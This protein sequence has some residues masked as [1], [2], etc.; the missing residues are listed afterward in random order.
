MIQPINRTTYVPHIDGLR[1]AAVL[2]V[3]AYHLDSAWLPAGLGGVDIFFV[4]SGFVVSASLAEFRKSTPQAFFAYFYARRMLRILPALVVCLLVTNVA[5]MLFVP[6]AWLSDANQQTG[7]YAFFGLS[8][9]ILAETGNGY[10]APRA[11]FNPY[12]HTWSLGVEE[13]FYL[14][15]PP[16]F[17][18]WIAGGRSR[19]VSA[20]LFAMGLVASLVCAAWL[21]KDHG[22]LA[23]YMIYARFW[24]L[25]AGV[26]LYQTLVFT[27]HAFSEMHRPSTAPARYGAIA[28]ALLVAAGLVFARPRQFPFPGALL[29]VAGTL[30]LLGFLH[31]RE[32]RG[33]VM[34]ALQLPAVVFVGQISYSLYLWHWPVFVLLRWTTGLET[35]AERSSAV[36]LTFALAIASY[37]VI[38]RPPR[39]LGKLRA[40]PR[41]A[42]I[43]AGAFLV[44][45][46]WQ[47]AQFVTAKAPE[48][49]LTQVARNMPDWYAGRIDS[50]G[51]RNCQLRAKAENLGVV[52]VAIWSGV[53]CS[54]A[55]PSMPRLFVIGDSHAQA[56][57]T[58]MPVVAMDTGAEVYFYSN[59]GCPFLSLQLRREGVCVQQTATSTADMLA[60]MH[61][62]DILFMP[63]LRLDRLTDQ[64]EHRAEMAKWDT[65]LLA[66]DTDPSRKRAVDEA[67]AALKPFAERGVR[68]VFE[69]PKPLFRAPAFRCVDW[70]NAGNPICAP[71]LTMDR[72]ELVRYRAPVMQSFSE[73][74]RRVPGVT[75]WDPLPLL[76]PDS[77]CHATR[78]GH[79]LYYDGDH[80]SGYANRLLAPA[81]ERSM[82]RLAEKTPAAD[83]SS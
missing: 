57:A 5:E 78:D 50:V 73:I 33:I 56:Y 41:W 72:G 59:G 26:L 77:V 21:A 44:V 45:G 10:F 48:W 39:R 7:L 12:M 35:L 16:L 47:L 82:E 65:R 75:I 53:E 54:Q 32:P 17:A 20:A 8:N 74:A 64:N 70:F 58:M 62:D 2:S 46:S 49:S 42:V 80:I 76:C 1:A 66:G 79:P 67:V 63:S 4:I 25:A 38:E 40:V 60:R 14:I 83:A 19:V 11:E 36:V 51:P 30:G 29:P 52:S 69:A 18:A 55:R 37:Y 15:F 23:F 6:N 34:R 31:G 68:I 27:G 9:Y 24:E 3:I 81:F 22:D 28:S 71:G 43:L 61:A 13:Q